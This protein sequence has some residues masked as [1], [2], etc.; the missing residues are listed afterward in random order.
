LIGN[1]AKLAERAAETRA[2]SAA[3]QLEITQYRAAHRPVTLA[4]VQ[5]QRAERDSTWQAIKAGTRALGE[6]AT[7][8]E[9]EVAETDALS[10]QRHDKA[11]EETELQSRLDRLQRQQQ[12]LAELDA[13]ALQEQRL[14]TDLEQGWDQQMRSLGLPGM[15][16][17]RIESWR[18]AR[19]RV[20]QA[21][22]TLREAQISRDDF[23]RG[24]SG[25]M[26]AL[27]EVLQSIEP[28]AARPELPTLLRRAEQILESAHTA[29]ERRKALVTQ[30]TRARAVLNEA[31][32][33]REEARQTLAAW[34]QELR[35]NLA[36]AHLP[37][38]ATLGT[39]RGALGLFEDMSRQLEKIRELR[40]NRIDLMRRDL[41]DFAAAARSLAEYVDP[42]LS[43]QP[44]EQI[45]L[46]LESRL[47]QAIA[48]EQDRTRL[49]HSLENTKGEAQT[50]RHRI[51]AAEGSLQ[52]LAQRMPNPLDQDALREAIGRSDRHRHLTCRRDELLEQLLR[53]GDGL[54]RITLEAELSGA[55]VQGIPARLLDIR[56]EID[57]LV[58]QQNQWSSERSIA[59]TALHQIAGQ[60][61]A[62]RAESRRQEALA[63]M[64]NAVER[65]IRVHTAAKLLRWSIERFRESKQGPM[66]AR[67]GE[68]FRGLTA[69]ALQK[70][71][72]DYDSS[73]LTLSG[74]RAG[75]A[76]VGIDGMSE[77]TRDQLYLAL[78]LAALELHLEQTAPLPFIADD[79][80]IN[81]DDARAEAGFAALSTLA[82]LTQVIFLSH[83]DHLVPVARAVFGERLNVV[84]LG[85]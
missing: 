70:L 53:E 55:E 76:L 80:F 21:A 66:L 64:G 15:P 84:N 23:L 26:T 39:V 2:E 41:A 36:L 69:G 17:L 73:P 83:H 28:D 37:P 85:A 72:V 7:G 24:V 58:G 79:L 60:D 62:A 75:G 30:Q 38:D 1:A 10:D 65:Y 20:L 50:A 54:D 13:R 12:H 8:Y 5:R 34:Q 63:R 25:A 40:V 71:V 18:A 67:A 56:N 82:G 16:L 68:I 51:A 47:K 9:Q 49:T 29:R 19:E 11:Q 59:E 32:N 43:E 48:D 46:T 31:S 3:L 27:A 35:K 78:R 4:D 14:L 22:T 6:A 81:Y 52:P 45:A 57:G 61:D 44:A 77:G 74:Q 42:S 33:R